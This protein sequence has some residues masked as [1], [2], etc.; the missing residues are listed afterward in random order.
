MFIT[1]FI[2]IYFYKKR[3]NASEH[4]WNSIGV[5]KMPPKRQAAE[6]PATQVKRP[7][8]D[9]TRFAIA[10]MWLRA[11]PLHIKGVLDI[12]SAYSQEL[13]GTCMLALTG[14]TSYVMA[15]AVLP[16]GRKL[17]SGSADYTVRVWEDGAC[18]LTLGVY[19]SAIE[20]QVDL[21][22]K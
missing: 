4:L 5:S 16:D 14:H 2:K 20:L 8:G 22:K 9:P 17:A 21:M 15:P 10:D 13:E 18:L 19:S 11:S 12:I 3:K 6:Q 7:H 1:N